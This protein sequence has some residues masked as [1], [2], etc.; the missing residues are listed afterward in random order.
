MGLHKM[1]KLKKL[2]AAWPSDS[3]ALQPWLDEQSISRQLSY[4]Y[5]QS[6]WIEKIGQGAYIKSGDKVSWVGGLFAIQKHLKLSLHIGART[7]LERAGYGHYVPMGNIF[8][9]QLFVHES[10]KFIMPK[11]FGE[12][13]KD[14]VRIILIRRNLFQSNG[15]SLGLVSKNFNGIELSIATP[16]RAIVEVLELVPQKIRYD[17]AYY[18]MEGLQT[19]RPKLVQELL[20]AIFL[21]DELRI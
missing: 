6:G 4:K 8:L 12:Y 3:V 20:L 15:K 13:F 10:K 18:L 9:L 7:A 21:E 2:L 5:S 1:E 11:W 16:E 14:Q 17:H 19:L